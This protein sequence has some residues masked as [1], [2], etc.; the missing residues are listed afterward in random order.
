MTRIVKITILFFIVFA[1]TSSTCYKN[2][3]AE[4]EIPIYSSVIDIINPPDEFQVL[5]RLRTS[6]NYEGIIVF[7]T[8][9]VWEIEKLTS[10][11]SMFWIEHIYPDRVEKIDF[12]EL[13]V[14]K[15]QIGFAA[16]TTYYFWANN[17]ESLEPRNLFV[18]FKRLDNPYSSFEPKL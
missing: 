14:N 5:F 1:M 10:L 17:N 7:E 6:N 11:S 18:R 15:Y 4:D 16:D 12:G 9:S 13:A 2:L 3:P 8:N